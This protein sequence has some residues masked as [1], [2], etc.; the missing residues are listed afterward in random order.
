MS[1]AQLH[2]DIN[3][4]M[5]MCSTCC[6]SVTVSFSR[7]SKLDQSSEFKQV[8]AKEKLNSYTVGKKLHALYQRYVLKIVLLYFILDIIS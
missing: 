7:C 4:K 8:G 6:W 1:I 2:N 5:C 3:L